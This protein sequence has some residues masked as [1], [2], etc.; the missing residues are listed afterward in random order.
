MHR[1]AAFV[2]LAVLAAIAAGVVYERAERREDDKRLPRVG[3]AVDIGAR[4]LNIYCSGEGGPA[5]ILSAAAPFSGYSWI[6]AQRKIAKFTQACWYDRAG[7]GWSDPGPD[8]RDSTASAQDL[9]E[10]LRRAGIAPPY[11]L[12]GE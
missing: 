7:F 5:V 9:H 8:P 3:Q 2:V 1:S 10:L 12:V 6:A 4:S 11:I